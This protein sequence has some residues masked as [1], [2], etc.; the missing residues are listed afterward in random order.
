MI[1]W[2]GL[3]KKIKKYSRLGLVR[4]VSVVLALNLASK[5]LMFFANIY[6][7][8]ALGAVNLG[9]SSQ[10]MNYGQQGALIPGAGFDQVA[11]KEI[12]QNHQLAPSI[13]ISI[14]IFRVI[15]AVVVLAVWVI[16][17]WIFVGE[18]ELRMIWLLGGILMF[19]NSINIAFVFQGLSKLSTIAI[20]SLLS[21]LVW[22]VGVGG[23]FKAY[24][25]LGSD[26]LISVI[27]NLIALVFMGVQIHKMRL[28]VSI[29]HLKFF[30]WLESICQL[31]K[32]SWYYGLI[33]IFVFFYSSSQIIIVGYFCGDKEAGIYKTAVLFGSGLL[34]I[35]NSINGFLLPKLVE[36]NASGLDNL[37]LKQLQI[38]KI[39]ILIGLPL[40]SL[41]V[42]LAPYIYQDLLGAEFYDGKLA[43]QIIAI[44]TLVVF[45][46]QIYFWGLTALNQHRQVLIASICGVISCVIF[47]WVLIPIFGMIGVAIASLITEIVIHGYCYLVNKKYY[48]N[49][50]V[51]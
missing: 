29:S 5:L 51:N 42:L 48:K 36:W 50:L 2:N 33:S 40:V 1:Y 19:I 35:F 25:P 28:I 3:C 44:Q 46:G 16:A 8:K 7:A 41:A 20:S 12:S 14:L 10:I 31:F 9:I 37:Q 45:I 24:M 4:Q 21:S 15:V 38:T 27:A 18:S 17:S 30:D 11:V 49:S 6:A 47:N 43:F 34:L 13:T 23:F 32:Q 39:Y 22:C 26:I